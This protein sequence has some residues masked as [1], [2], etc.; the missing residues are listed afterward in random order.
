MKNSAIF[1]AI[2]SAFWF[3][4]ANTFVRLLGGS[5]PSVEILLGRSLIGLGLCFMAFGKTGFDFGKNKKL[6]LIRGTTGF[7]A[8]FC[9]I[10]AITHLPIAD[11]ITLFYTNPVFALLLGIIFLRERPDILAFFCVLMSIL[12]VLLITRPGFLFTNSNLDTFS[13]LVALIAALFSAAAYVTV[14]AIK[15]REN[16]ITVVAYLYLVSAPAAFFLSLPVWVWPTWQDLG[17]LLAIGCFTQ[18]GQIAL[19]KALSKEQA[20]I[21]TAVGT[22]Q[23]PFVTVIGIVFFQETPVLL[24]ICGTILIVAGAVI[25][26][27]KK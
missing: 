16:P 19:V 6:L 20:G 15:G 2:S 14:H 5:L 27:L 26:N 10:Y 1:L 21:V 8:L 12:G 18:F 13:T 25:L 3:S 23:V 4:I 11:A 22:I 9:T 7:I 17:Y 24:T